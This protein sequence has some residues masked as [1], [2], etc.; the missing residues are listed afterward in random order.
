MNDPVSVKPAFQSTAQD[1]GVPGQLGPSEWN[2]ARLFSGGLDGDVCRRDAASPTGA[3]WAPAASTD[4]R[5]FGAIGDGVADDTVALRA[6]I[7][8]AGVNGTLYFPARTFIVSGSLQP[9]AGQT[10]IGYG[11]RLKRPNQVSTTTATNITTSGNQTITVAS[12]AGLAVGMDVSVFNGAS[13]DPASHVILS[14][15]GN[16]VQLGTV[17][18]V[19]FPTGGTLATCGVL[20]F[21]QV[22]AAKVSILGLEFDGNRANNTLLNK[23]ELMKAVWLAGDRSVLRDCYVH[24]CAAEGILVGGIGQVVDHCWVENTNGNGIHFSGSTDGRV[25]GCYVKSCNLGGAAVGH[26]DGAIIF[27]NSTGDS[28]ISENYIDTAISCIGSIDSDDNSSVIISGNVCKNATT[29]AVEVGEVSNINVGRVLITGNLFYACGPMRIVNNSGTPTANT[30]PY[31]VQVSGNYCEATKIEIFR[32]FDVSIIGNTFVSL[33]DTTGLG[34]YLYDV[35]RA[36][37]SGNIIRGFAYGI[38]IDGAAGQLPESVN[39]IGNTLHNQLTNGVRFNIAGALAAV[40][41][42]NTIQTEAGYASASYAGLGLTNHVNAIGNVLDLQSGQYGILCPNGGASTPGA[43]VA[44]N[45]I[46]SAV[47]ASIR[48]NGG[49][50][51]NIIANNFV[52]Q[53]ISDGGTPNNTLSGNVTIL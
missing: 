4:V 43:V 17:F 31:R 1:I 3:T 27:S 38:Y 36:I 34:L 13:Y 12:A 47:T 21:G 8:G 24:D 46:R 42:G 41:Q 15:A 20:I 18:T 7:T 23:W 6:A 5:L 33:S 48:T 50:Q 35:K 37:I 26:A 52:Q 39:I 29:Y 14:I 10:W 40:V 49:S 44:N 51:K 30:G 32:S 45:V 25:V 11:A 22:S 19:A 9:L 28:I 16:V 2:A 53:A